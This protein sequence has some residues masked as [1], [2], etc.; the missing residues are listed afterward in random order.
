[1]SAMTDTLQSEPNH[2]V[3]MWAMFASEAEK[4]VI[5]RR[6]PR[7]HFQ[8]ID[9]D[10]R[11]G[12]FTPGQWM[13]GYVALCDLSPSGDRLI[14][15]AHQY[16]P[17]AHRFRSDAEAQGSQQA[18]SLYEPLREDRPKPSRNKKNARRKIPRYMRQ[19]CGMP[20][21]RRRWTSPIRRN[22][23][24]WTAISKPPY[25]SALAIWPSFGHW[26]GG[27]VFLSENAI[28]LQDDNITPKENAPVPD[29]FVIHSV[30][31]P[32]WASRRLSTNA[33]HMFKLDKPAW[34]EFSAALR[35]AG[36]RWVEWMAP[37]KDKTLYFA[38]DGSIY[39][40]EDWQKVAP[41]RY[42]VEAQELADFTGSRFEQI[43]PPDE[44][45]QW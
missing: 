43:P 37:R 40:L 18:E 30:F 26:T 16:H 21:P 19:A 17:H 36:A 44:A 25:F 33:W 31:A 3:R 8:L 4:A 27:G 32:E 2:R 34:D 11:K 22:E 13:Y 41:E 28:V 45:L 1:M 14:Y 6:G 42:L 35:H 15:W 5:L 12:R 39:R 24:V 29:S 38:C 7:K 23:G 9:W 10:L 20:P